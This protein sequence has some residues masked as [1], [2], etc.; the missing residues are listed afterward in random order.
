MNAAETVLGIDL[1]GLDGPGADG[2]VTIVWGNTD[3]GDDQE[4][5]VVLLGVK[6]VEADDFLLSPTGMI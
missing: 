2:P 1:D 4:F 6:G 3:E 5:A